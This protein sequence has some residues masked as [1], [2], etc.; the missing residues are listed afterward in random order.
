MRALLFL[1]LLAGCGGDPID[2]GADGAPAGPDGGSEQPDATAGPALGDCSHFA[3]VADHV[4]FLNQSRIDYEP[5][6]RYR[7]LP[8]QGEYHTTITFPMTFTW[9]DA[10]AASAQ[11]EASRVAAGGAPA[12]TFVAG[13]N[14]ENRDMHIDGLGTAAWRITADELPGDWEIQGWGGHEYAAL[15]PS[16]GSARMGFFYHDFGGGPVIATMGVAAAVTPA[17]RVVWV[18]QMGE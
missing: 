3:T 10:L 13:Q 14:G 2:P 12:G 15:H 16:N 6:E 1:A 4:A 11:A 7:G 5:H 17:C 18:L 8:W 9:S